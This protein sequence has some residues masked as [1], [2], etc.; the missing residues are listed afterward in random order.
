M[1]LDL[2]RDNLRSG[3]FVDLIA[4]RSN[5]RTA[6]VAGTLPGCESIARDNHCFL[7]GELIA[8]TTLDSRPKKEAEVGTTRFIHSLSTCRPP[9]MVWTCEIVAGPL[10]RSGT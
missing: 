6:K 10:R 9:T 7:F 8:A 4:S 5:R 1:R 2:A 3:P